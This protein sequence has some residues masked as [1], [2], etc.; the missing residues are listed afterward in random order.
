MDALPISSI[1][2]NSLTT[3]PYKYHHCLDHRRV[4]VPTCTLYGTPSCL[5]TAQS[6]PYA[7]QKWQSH[8]IALPVPLQDPATALAGIT[9]PK[10][11]LHAR[12]HH[13]IPFTPPT[14]GHLPYLPGSSK[15]PPS[16]FS[17]LP[18]STDRSLRMLVGVL[19]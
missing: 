10:P 19:Y 15:N 6:P 2:V 3:C 9:P 1:V 8:D 17:L 7:Y 4:L 13:R 14:T 5:T 18:I 12:S 11:K 16:T